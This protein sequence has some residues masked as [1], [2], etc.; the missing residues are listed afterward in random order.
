M[1]SVVRL[2]ALS[3]KPPE[4]VHRLLSAV[5]GMERQF[6]NTCYLP[7]T[8]KNSEGMRVY[9]RDTL[10]TDVDLQNTTTNCWTK[11]EGQGKIFKWPFKCSLCFYP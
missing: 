8:T 9:H 5:P 4:N 10:Y 1:G 11:R 7:E 6:I 3:A 2:R